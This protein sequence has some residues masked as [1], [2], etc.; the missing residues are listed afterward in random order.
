MKYVLDENDRQQIIFE[1]MR[2]ETTAEQVKEKYNLSSLLSIYSWVGKY[3][4][5]NEVLSLPP[6]T[7]DDMANK[8]IFSTI[9]KAIVA[10]IPSFQ[11]FKSQ[12]LPRCF[13]AGLPLLSLSLHKGTFLIYSF[14]NTAE[15]AHVKDKRYICIVMC[16]EKEIPTPCS[17]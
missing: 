12:V 1:I 17:R 15:I 11:H 13:C 16:D 6:Q 5:Q 4:S 9:S 7:E 14:I 8:S 3:V 2:G 10:K